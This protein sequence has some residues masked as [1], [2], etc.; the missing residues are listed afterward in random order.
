[1]AG[2]H[3]LHRLPLAAVGRSPKHPM[4]GVADSIA[5]VPEFGGDAA[6][7]GIFQRASFLAP[8]NF[9]GDFGG[10]LKLVAAII[11]GPGTVGFHKNAV[12]GIG[13]EIFR[14]PGAGKQADVGHAN[15]RQAVPAFGA[16]C[17]AGAL[18]AHE[19]RGFTAGEIAAE[20]AALDDVDALRGNAF[21]VVG[22]G[23]EAGAVR[24]AGIGDD[25]HDWRG[26]TQVIQFVDGEKAGAG[27][28]RFLAENAIEFDGMPD[29]FVNLQ[30]ELAAAEDQRGFFSG[31]CAEEWRATASSAI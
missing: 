19:T 16:H 28:I 12:V 9:P 31:H 22:E 1:V 27:K 5:R 18:Q 20:F 23:A 7:A 29:G 14:R 25:I 6:I 11:D 13:D 24:G 3:G 8:F 10:E 15:H 2:A 30:A 26:V 21:V 4:I 17:A